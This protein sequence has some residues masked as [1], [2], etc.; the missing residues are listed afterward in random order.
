MTLV[1]FVSTCRRAYFLDLIELI[2]ISQ[3]NALAGGPVNQNWLSLATGSKMEDELVV[4][5]IILKKKLELR[6]YMLHYLSFIAS[7][8]RTVI[9]CNLSLK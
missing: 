4:L 9:S 7:R 3:T 6:L 1:V 8:Y 5:L 2:D